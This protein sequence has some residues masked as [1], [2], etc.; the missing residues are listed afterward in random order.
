MHEHLECLKKIAI[1]NQQKNE[2]MTTLTE[3]GQ[4]DS[5]AMKVLTMLATMYVPATLIAVSTP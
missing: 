1:Q 4:E 5:K 3:Q 2:L